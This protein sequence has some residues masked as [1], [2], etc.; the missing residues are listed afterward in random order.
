MNLENR[1][2]VIGCTEEAITAKKVAGNNMWS[3]VRKGLLLTMVLIKV[4]ISM[5]TTKQ[6]VLS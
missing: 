4:Y 6:L 5:K 3:I 1:Y 2:Y